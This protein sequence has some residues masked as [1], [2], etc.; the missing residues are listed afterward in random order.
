MPKLA[1]KPAPPKSAKFSGFDR[2]AIQFWHELAAEMNRDWF[3]ANKE[4]Y[5][6]KWV[7]PMTALLSAVAAKAASA[8]KGFAISEPKVMRIYRDTRFA[9]DKSPY[10]TW[11]GASVNVGPARKAPKKDAVR[12]DAR[13]A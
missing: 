5:E 13:T 7:A 11:I 9:K 4:R 8:Y 2:D 1:T 10:K 6:T 12:G 3:M